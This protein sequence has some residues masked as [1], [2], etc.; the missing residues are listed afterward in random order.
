MS[1]RVP[2]DTLFACDCVQP[3]RWKYSRS[4]PGAL[5]V[6][7]LP[8]LKMGCPRQYMRTF[9][10][11]PVPPSVLHFPQLQAF[12]ILSVFF[13]LQGRLCV[14]SSS[15]SQTTAFVCQAEKRHVVKQRCPRRFPV[16]QW[17]NLEG[18]HLSLGCCSCSGRTRSDLYCVPFS[19][20]FS[21]RMTTAGSGARFDGCACT[22]AGASL[23]QLLSPCRP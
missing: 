19:P 4:N 8:E 9:T 15:V 20:E 11:R 2:D 7:I 14:Y 12:A 1:E 21:P 17:V 16:Y 5:S 23:S 3:E 10:E 6:V 18:H 22:R 13:F